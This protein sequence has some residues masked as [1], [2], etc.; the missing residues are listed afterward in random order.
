[1]P[2]STVIAALAAVT[3]LVVG[4]SAP[5]LGDVRVVKDPTKDGSSDVTRVRIGHTEGSLKVKIRVATKDD[6]AHFYDLW[7]DTDATDPGPEFVVTSTFEVLPRVSV[8]STE[9]FG[10][11]QGATRCTV[12]TAEA[13]FKTKTYRFSV[14]RRCLG[15][16]DQVRVSLEASDE[17]G[18][19][20]WVPGPHLFSAWV[21]SG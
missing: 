15:R 10:D 4:A 19:H 5:A 13:S 3:A 21:T 14:P 12:R 6:F 16:P 8:S 17:L 20:D 11:L 1:M 18:R 2:R 7:V 9:D